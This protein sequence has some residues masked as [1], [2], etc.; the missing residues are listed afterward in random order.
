MPKGVA[1]REWMDPGSESSISLPHNTK[2]PEVGDGGGI[3]EEESGGGE[4]N[5][6]IEDEDE[7]EVSLSM[8]VSPALSHRP[9][10]PPLPYG[11]HRVQRLRSQSFDDILSSVNNN[12]QDL[13]PSPSATDSLTSHARARSNALKLPSSGSESD[14]EPTS[15]NSL[16][17]A[18]NHTDL[19]RSQPEMASVDKLLSAAVAKGTGKLNQLG[20]R[21]LRRVR[22]GP[23]R[24]MQSLQVPL[25][26][27]PHSDHAATSGS[28]S[29]TGPTDLSVEESSQQYHSYQHHQ[30]QQQQLTQRLLAVGQRLRSS[31]PGLLRRM[32]VGGGGQGQSLDHAP[33][34]STDIGG[35]DD[36]GADESRTEAMVS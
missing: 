28:G 31:P 27:R 25:P 5:N 17:V 23:G 34:P 3:D 35:V 9:H 20:G 36:E 19:V 18:Y 8:P 33:P 14:E 4:K 32:G 7:K 22:G 6:E 2:H 10:P 15:R 21:L 13:P 11:R 29:D 1:D 24:R 26:P 30:Q 12:E 16:G